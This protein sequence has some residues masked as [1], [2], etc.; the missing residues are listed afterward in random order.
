MKS[1]CNFTGVD[2]MVEQFIWK[3]K[4]L[5]RGKEKRN[6]GAAVFPES[7]TYDP[8]SVMTTTR[9]WWRWMENNGK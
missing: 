3:D 4:H 7:K 8:G 5:R 9:H 1:Q 6:E 2:K